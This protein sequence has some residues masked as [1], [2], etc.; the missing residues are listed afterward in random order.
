MLDRSPSEVSVAARLVVLPTPAAA[1]VE[2]ASVPWWCWGGVAEV[3]LLPWSSVMTTRALPRR[4][5]V[6]AMGVW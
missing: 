6:T 5:A 1:G 3:R 4:H 2:L